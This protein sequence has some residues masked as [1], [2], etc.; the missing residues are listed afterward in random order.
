MKGLCNGIIFHKT[1]IHDFFNFNNWDCILQIDKKGLMEQ[2]KKETLLK[3][4]Q[5]VNEIRRREEIAPIYKGRFGFIQLAFYVKI[6]VR[7]SFI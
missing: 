1:I 6:Y 2:L 5:R 3:W 7:V 4:G